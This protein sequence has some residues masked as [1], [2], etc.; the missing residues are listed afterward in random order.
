[1]Q[2]TRNVNFRR[3]KWTEKGEKP[4]RRLDKDDLE[5]GLREFTT[6]KILFCLEDFGALDEFAL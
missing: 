1:V 5:S 4:D 6:C 2:P 3:F